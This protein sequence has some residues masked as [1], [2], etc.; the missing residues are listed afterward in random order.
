MTSANE[1]LNEFFNEIFI[2]SFTR[3]EDLIQI[4]KNENVPRLWNTKN[5]KRHYESIIGLRI[6]N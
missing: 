4:A 5:N 3:L 6:K 1:T 2:E